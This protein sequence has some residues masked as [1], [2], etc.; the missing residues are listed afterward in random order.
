MHPSKQPAQNL[1]SETN[2]RTSA[3]GRQTNTPTSRNARRRDLHRPT[4]SARKKHN[5]GSVNRSKHR[6]TR[7]DAGS[8]RYAERTA[9]IN[10]GASSYSNRTCSLASDRVVAMTT[11]S[12]TF[13]CDLRAACS[14]HLTM[15]L[16]DSMGACGTV[17]Q[18]RAAGPPVLCRI[19]RYIQSESLDLRCV[20]WGHR[21]EA[22]EI[23]YRCYRLGLVFRGRSRR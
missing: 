16:T 5:P 8:E 20:V 1:P 12:A 15:L 2:H 23:M 4:S 14:G 17:L 19:D 13:E 22:R 9:M 11:C 10:K 3:L 21:V 7:A 18:D 6:R